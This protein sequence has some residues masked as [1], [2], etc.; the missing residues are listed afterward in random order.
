MINASGTGVTHTAFRMGVVGTACTKMRVANFMN[1]EGANGLYETK[2]TNLQIAYHMLPAF[3]YRN[4]FSMA[5][6]FM[7]CAIVGAFGR[8]GFIIITFAI[9]QPIFVCIQ[10]HVW[11]NVNA[12]VAGPNGDAKQRTKS[13]S[14]ATRRTHKPIVIPSSQMAEPRNM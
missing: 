8:M 14:A 9:E 6:G 2:C 7:A 3:P 12:R 1:H 5:V 4:R 13:V 11:T 10:I